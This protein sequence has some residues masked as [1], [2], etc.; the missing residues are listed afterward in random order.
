VKSLAIVDG[1]DEVSNVEHHLGN[2]VLMSDVS[3]APFLT[4]EFC[5]DN[6]L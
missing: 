6:Q 4:F 2:V 3:A 1:C 5:F